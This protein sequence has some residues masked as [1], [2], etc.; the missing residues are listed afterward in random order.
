MSGKQQNHLTPLRF[1]VCLQLSLNVLRK[2]LDKTRVSRPPVNNTPLNR[3]RRVGLP[4]CTLSFQ[5]SPPLP[6]LVQRATSGRTGILGVLSECN[7][8]SSFPIAEPIGQQ[9]VIHGLCKRSG[10]AKSDV[11]LVRRSL[12]RYLIQ[13]LAHLG[14]LVFRPLA[15]WRATSNIGVLFLNLRGPATG[16]ERS[17]V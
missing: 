1:R 3:T 9:L 6:Q 17:E 13:H 2:S 15:N 14:T 16:N 5:A 11:G 7:G 8:T 12:W 4:I 10:V